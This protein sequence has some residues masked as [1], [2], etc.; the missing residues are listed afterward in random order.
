VEL[1]VVPDCLDQMGLPEPT[2]DQ[3][4]LDQLEAQVLLV[5]SDHLDLPDLWDCLV[6]PEQLVTLVA[7]AVQDFQAWLANLVSP[8]RKVH[9]AMLVHRE[10]L[11]FKESV[12]LMA[13]KESVEL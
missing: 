4:S 11:D 1:L 8:V 6:V 7:S 12:V 10:T 5:R 3:D 2:V 13:Y 9:R